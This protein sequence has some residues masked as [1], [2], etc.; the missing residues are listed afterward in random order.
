[1]DSTLITIDGNEPIVSTPFYLKLGET[2]GEDLA[3][4]TQNI[5]LK[6][7][8]GYDNNF[9]LNKRKVGR[10][11]L[12]TSAIAPGKRNVKWKFLP[13]KLPCRFIETVLSMEYVKLKAV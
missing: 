4:Q 3:Q 7:G 6:N 9:L 12:V 11:S 10:M 2:I 1:M 5:Q 13:K 8:L